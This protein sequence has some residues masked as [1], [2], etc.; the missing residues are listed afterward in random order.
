MAIQSEGERTF[1]SSSNA[2]LLGLVS[3][4][5]QLQMVQP[6][7]DI[8]VSYRQLYFCQYSHQEVQE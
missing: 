3:T 1:Q 5:K 7:K 6:K 4:A 2:T 8:P